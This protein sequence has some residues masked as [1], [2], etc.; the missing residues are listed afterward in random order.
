MISFLSYVLLVMGIWVEDVSI[1]LKLDSVYI[2][3]AVFYIYGTD[4]VVLN[5]R[6]IDCSI[7]LKNSNV[8]F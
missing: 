3:Y 1:L 4:V 7:V 6:K 2:I 8:L 5:N